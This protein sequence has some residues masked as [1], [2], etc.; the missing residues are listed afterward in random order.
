METV[1]RE[2]RLLSR[3]VVIGGTAVFADLVATWF[4]FSCSCLNSSFP[5]S[6]GIW[7]RQQNK[8]EISSLG[9]EKSNCVEEKG[10]FCPNFWPW[11]FGGCR[12]Y[13]S[14]CIRVTFCFPS[15]CVVPFEYALYS[16]A[17]HL[18]KKGVWQIPFTI[19]AFWPLFFYLLNNF[20]LCTCTICTARSLMPDRCAR[21]KV[22]SCFLEVE[23]GVRA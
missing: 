12:S 19:H 18:V 17:R 21:L 16:A 5:A 7:R 9:G 11:P 4:V 13:M 15:V 8:K 22:A 2:N 3:S 23:R 6:A 10:V 1:C 14:M 20:S